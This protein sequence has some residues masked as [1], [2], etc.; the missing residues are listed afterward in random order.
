[1]RS[2]FLSVVLGLA[3]LG[4]TAVTPTQSH[5]AWWNGWEYT[6]YSYPAYV[7]SYPGYGYYSPG[8]ASYYHPG[9]A[10]YYYPGYAGYY[11]YPTYSY[12][13]PGYANYSYRYWWR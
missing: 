3:S 6:G 8:Y 13:Y 5:A 4:L 12:Y 1:M 7:Y 10:S 11:S 2:L 9:Y